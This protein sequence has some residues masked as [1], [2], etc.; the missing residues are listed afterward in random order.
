MYPQR[1]RRIRQGALAHSFTVQKAR[2][3][4]KR[5][6]VATMYHSARMR[7]CITKGDHGMVGKSALLFF[8][9]VMHHVL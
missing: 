3:H 6:M 4:P 5:E 2:K 8:S 1:T 7:L 9:K